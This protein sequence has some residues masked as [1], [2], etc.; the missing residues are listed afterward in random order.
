LGFSLRWDLASPQS[1]VV[2]IICSK[3]IADRCNVIYQSQI[4]DREVLR[5][6]CRVDVEVGEWEHSRLLPLLDRCLDFGSPHEIWL[7]RASRSVLRDRHVIVWAADLVLGAVTAL[8]EVLIA[9]NMPALASVTALAGLGVA[10]SWG[11]A[12]GT[13]HCR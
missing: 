2:C 13:S 9:A 12:A 5:R 1:E 10:S 6:R 11:T 7:V 3:L 8:R 4:L